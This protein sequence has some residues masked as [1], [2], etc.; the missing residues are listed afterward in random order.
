[1]LHRSGERIANAGQEVPR[2]G[3]CFNEMG[4][5][6]ALR[7]KV[8]DKALLPFFDVKGSGGVHKAEASR[9]IHSLNNA[10]Q[11]T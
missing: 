9:A 11:A 5:R 6:P 2:A 1:M 3:Y 4:H 10:M 7:T 8:D